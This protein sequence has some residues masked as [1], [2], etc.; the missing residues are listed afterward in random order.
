MENSLEEVK[1]ENEK[2]KEIISLKSDLISITAHQ[3]RTSLSALKWMLK[4]FLDKDIGEVT[5]EQESFLKKA[6]ESNQ[7]MIDAVNEMLLINKDEDATISYK[8]EKA[9]V[10]KLIESVVFEFIGESHKLGIEI[11][12][13]KPTE[14]IPELNIDLYK[15]RVVL[16]NLI[17]NAIK[18]SHDG[19]KIFISI[20][21][22]GSEIEFS[23]KDTGI[24]IKT[25]DQDRIFNKFFRAENAKEKK[26]VGTGLGLVTTK[27]IVEKHGGKIWFKS[28]ENHGS[29]FYFTLPVSTD[30]TT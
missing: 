9:N 24:G 13:L 6:Y 15:I 17:E 30:K 4:M 25:E 29:T 14:E 20:E 12:F 18:Y 8:F 10:I 1:K 19:D 2:L 3:L 22:K 11:I 23:V 16:Q 5:K 7:I 21:N 26:I 27:S 28:Q